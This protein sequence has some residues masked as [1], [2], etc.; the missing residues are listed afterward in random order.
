[1]SAEPLETSSPAVPAK[2]S[3]FG[4]IV[5][6]L[7]LAGLGSAVFKRLQ[8]QEVLRERA[9][10]ST[11][12]LSVRVVTAKAAPAT[13]TLNL[14]GSLRPREQVVLYART[15]GFLRQWLAD[16]GDPV[17]KGQTLAHIDAP[18]LAANLSQARARFEQA[19]A[20]IGLVRAQH[21]RTSAM[22]KG[23]TLSPQDL[24]ASALRLAAAES[25]LATSSAE[26]DR[27]SALVSFTAVTAPFEGTVTR[28]LLDN[29]ALVTNGVTAL[30]EIASTNDLRV[31]VEIPQWAASQ[32]QK[33]T[34]ATVTIGKDPTPWAVEVSRTAG[35]LDPTLRTLGVQ[36]TFKSPPVH[37]VP[38]SYARVKFEVPRSEPMTLVPGATVAIRNG[39]PMVGLVQADH[40]LHF[41]E[42]KIS[43][44]LG[45]EVELQSGVPVGAKLALYP[46]PALN[47]GDAVTPVEGAP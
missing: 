24:D 16:M 19:K 47:D 32:V 25:E 11:T 14:P 10:P 15:N 3:W 33:G 22:V 44:D 29:G 1:M 34:A 13:A 23:G 26:V 39:V 31:D 2:A 45:K 8:I 41:V 18:E 21:E 12:P 27:L 30:F 5:V 43:R 35:A 38:G 40:S 17:K 9:A 28:R 46:P 42:A 20:S 7:L 4:R 37:V 6:L 36:L